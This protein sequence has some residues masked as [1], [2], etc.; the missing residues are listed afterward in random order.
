[1]DKEINIRGSIAALE[2]NQSVDFDRSA[3]KVSTVRNAAYAICT[4]T[5]RKIIVNLVSPTVVR[6][7]R[8]Y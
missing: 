2:V 3:V 6:A 4:D 7:S 8:T 1:M 5:G